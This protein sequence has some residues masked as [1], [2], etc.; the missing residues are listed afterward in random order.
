LLEDEPFRIS[1][2]RIGWEDNFDQLRSVSAIGQD[3]QFDVGTIGDWLRFNPPALIVRDRMQ[4]TNQPLGTNPRFAR[5]PLAQFC[6]QGSSRFAD[7]HAAIG[8][9]SDRLKTG[10]VERVRVEGDQEWKSIGGWMAISCGDEITVGALGALRRWASA[11]EAA[12][13]SPE[14]ARLRLQS[15][16]AVVRSD[17]F[18]REQQHSFAAEPG[19]CLSYSDSLAGR[20]RFDEADIRGR[21]SSRNRAAVAGRRPS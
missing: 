15:A 19:D 10:F 13:P 4:P 11:E 6:E 7:E 21:Q 5:K 14:R 18:R 12:Q 9:A 16:R 17:E 3:A 1:D 20:W 2:R 8:Q